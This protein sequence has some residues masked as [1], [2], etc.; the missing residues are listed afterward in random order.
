MLRC[1][2]CKKWIVVPRHDVDNDLRLVAFPRWNRRGTM[3]N[4][5]RI[6]AIS[7][8]TGYRHSI[9]KTDEDGEARFGE[10]S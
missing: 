4:S 10:A 7:V 6:Q 1:S 8:A 2:H 3:A 5:Q 9:A